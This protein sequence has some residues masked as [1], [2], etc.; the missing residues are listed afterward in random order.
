MTTDGTSPC[1]CLN[2]TSANSSEIAPNEIFTHPTASSWSEWTTLRF[3]P[4]R[5]GL[6]SASIVIRDVTRNVINV[7][8]SDGVVAYLLVAEKMVTNAVVSAE[9]WDATAHFTFA[10]RLVVANEPID[11]LISP[12]NGHNDD[13]TTISAIFRREADVCD[14]GPSMAALNWAGASL[15]TTPAHPF[16]DFLGGGATWDVGSST[17]ASG[18]PFTTMPRAFRRVSN[19]V[20]YFGFGQTYAGNVTS[21]GG[22]PRVMLATNGVANLMD[23]NDDKIFRIAP[24]EIWMHPNSSQ[25]PVIHAKVPSD[26]VYH[27]RAYGRDVANG[28][29]GIRFRLGVGGVVPA[30]ARISLEKAEGAYEAALDGPRLWLK[31]GETVDAVVDPNTSDISFDGTG[32]GFCYVKEGEATARVVNV[33]FTE[34]VNGKFSQTSQRPR[35]G[36]ANWNKWNAFTA[37]DAATASLANCY[38]ADGETR[39]NATVTLARDSGAAIA[40]G[41]T[42]DALFYSYV[43]STGTADTYTFTI[44]QLAKNAPYT[45]YLY[46]VKSTS[47]LGNATFTVG[48]V[49]KGVEE[50]WDVYGRKTLTRFDATSDANGVITGTFAASSA[51]GGVFNG[52]TIVGDFPEYKESVFVITIR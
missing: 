32:V 31:A 52:L 47:E 38:E 14:A 24:N 48:G 51:S 45:L 40:K 22:L 5:S 11:I 37:G 43:S 16:A 29:D 50:P 39:R 18:M 44:S 41:S 10:P 17:V 34:R 26:G 15:P 1:I 2:Y 27:A 28:N 46:S 19:S 12:L 8:G 25:Y 30:L 21:D 36:W 4:T 7:S 35:E 33:H 20:D 6:Y 49:T 13:G 3:R 23:A 42:N 9:T